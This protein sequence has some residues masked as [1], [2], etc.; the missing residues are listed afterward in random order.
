[1]AEKEA[2]RTKFFWLV[3][4]GVVTL[5]FGVAGALVTSYL[6]T[7]SPKLI[8]TVT[9]VDY[10]EGQ[11]N[12]LGVVTL[13][14]SNPGRKEIETLE[15][16]IT[17]PNST[18]KEPRVTG[19][20]PT[21]LT[22][23]STTNSVVVSVPFLNPQ[24]S[25][26]LQILVEPPP[27]EPIKSDVEVRGK[28]VR[29]L[30]SSKNDAAEK[31]RLEIIPLVAGLMTAFVANALSVRLLVRKSRLV[32]RLMGSVID[33][34]DIVLG[35]DKQEMF[36]FTLGLNGFHSYAERI[37]CHH[38]K[39]SWLSYSDILTENVLAEARD[40]SVTLSRAI[41]VLKIILEN[42]EGLRPATAAAIN[43]NIAR[44]CAVQG[45]TKQ[46]AT[47]IKTARGEH[48]RMAEGRQELIPELRSL[49]QHD[50]ADDAAV[51]SNHP[52]QPSGEVGRS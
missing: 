35:Y 50:T 29:G 34:K 43:V 1:M 10:F 51:T 13:D 15:C 3:V 7:S 6:S 49:T 27:S 52:M 41:D 33:E 46:A 8:Y 32:R 16:N 38:R 20:A 25:L 42:I 31:T 19:L 30:E 22:L 4:G 5:V 47:Y 11:E 48:A 12:N 17:L 28:G 37:R 40:D 45:D 26:S 36:A 39:M 44:L 24:E 2:P 23:E 14:V 18:V 9:A 21:G